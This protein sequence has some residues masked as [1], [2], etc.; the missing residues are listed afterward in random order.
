MTYAQVICRK[1]G[2]AEPV[3]NPEA[4]KGFCSPCYLSSFYYNKPLPTD[5]ECKEYVD[6]Y[7]IGLRKARGNCASWKANSCLRNCNSCALAHYVVRLETDCD[8]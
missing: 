3:N 2:C 6:S 1:K 5:E 4:T 7:A 8:G